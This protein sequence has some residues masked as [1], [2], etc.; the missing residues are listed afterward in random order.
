MCCGILL[1]SFVRAAMQ[2]L[3]DSI[4]HAIVL[5]IEWVST[6]QNQI[7]FDIAKRTIVDTL[8]KSLTDSNFNQARITVE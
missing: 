1:Q 8:F 7:R 3:R 2:M 5:E 4:Q 6:S